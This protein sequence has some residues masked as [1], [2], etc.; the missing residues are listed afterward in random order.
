MDNVPCLQHTYLLFADSHTK[1]PSSFMLKYVLQT[2]FNVLRKRENVK[3]G[4]RDN[5]PVAL[6][7]ELLIRYRSKFNIDEQSSIELACGHKSE[8]NR[9]R[10]RRL[11]LIVS[12]ITARLRLACGHESL[13]IL[14]RILAIYVSARYP[15]SPFRLLTKYGCGFH[16]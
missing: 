10:G 3:R 4:E 14:L 12:L 2:G 13:S 9:S 1:L 7:H 6:G 15:A 11:I 8:E 5:R 16:N